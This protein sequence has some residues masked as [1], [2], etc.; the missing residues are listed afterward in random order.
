MSVSS[1]HS[2]T[3]S[4]PSIK[5][6]NASKLQ[7]SV[8]YVGNCRLLCS[9]HPSEVE[10]RK[11]LKKKQF[12]LNDQQSIINEAT[13][14]VKSQAAFQRLHTQKVVM[15][16]LSNDASHI[17][18]QKKKSKLKKSSDNGNGNIIS[19]LDMSMMS[20]PFMM[21]SPRRMPLE[22]EN[23]LST[24]TTPNTS[25]DMVEDSL[26][27]SLMPKNERGDTVTH[28]DLLREGRNRVRKQRMLE[29]EK[30]IMLHQHTINK[31]RE[32]REAVI[33]NQSS[34]SPKSVHY[35]KAWME[36]K[37]Q[38]MYRAQRHLNRSHF[39]KM[40]ADNVNLSPLSLTGKF[41]DPL[42]AEIKALPRPHFENNINT[43]KTKLTTSPSNTPSPD[44]ELQGPSLSIS[45]PSK[46]F[47][48]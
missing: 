30:N 21:P 22:I 44:L 20:G 1:Y 41:K 15:N 38:E 18:A 11:L 31:E 48:D 29:Q 8:T 32:E 23:L 14:M 3:N 7:T 25:K 37:R 26:Y 19:P 33:V 16:W 42:K 27:K 36:F 2:E 43:S 28:M 45:G 39:L 4:S 6:R 5:Y 24:E 17:A 34:H 13:E 46:V 12:G 35:A 9:S 10:F 47:D 40:V